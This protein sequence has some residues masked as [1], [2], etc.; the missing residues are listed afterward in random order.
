MDFRPNELGVYVNVAVGAPV[1]RVTVA[2][3]NVPV[4]P[5]SLGVIT[6]DV[7]TV[8]LITPTVKLVDAWLAYPSIGKLLN[9]NDIGCVDWNVRLDGFVKPPLF[10]IEIVSVPRADGVYVNVP[11]RVPLLRVSVVGLKVPPAPPSDGVTTTDDDSIPFVDTVKL[12]EAAP[13]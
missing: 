9:T 10:V 4:S 3:V 1:V 11:V 8:P 6:I 2:G 13:D 7:P 12:L 5:V